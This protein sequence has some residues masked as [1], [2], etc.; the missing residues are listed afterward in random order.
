MHADRDKFVA[1]FV[2]RNGFC[3]ASIDGYAVNI[4]NKVVDAGRT[5]SVHQNVMRNANQLPTA[6]HHPLKVCVQRDGQRAVQQAG[7]MHLS[8]SPQFG[9]LGYTGI[10]PFYDVPRLF[11]AVAAVLA[12][13]WG[14]DKLFIVFI[15]FILIFERD[16]QR[17]RQ[18]A[19]STL[20]VHSPRVARGEKLHHLLVGPV[21]YRAPQTIHVRC[22]GSEA[23]GQHLHQPRPQRF[24]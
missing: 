6:G 4:I 8:H 24:L 14:V 11:R 17:V 18:V 20:H 22:R 9:P 1:I 3:F 10:R 21:D 12:V 15:I 16:P 19:E 5:K 13:T 23:G 2:Q 7:K